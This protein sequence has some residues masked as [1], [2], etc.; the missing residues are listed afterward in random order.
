[1][2]QQTNDADEAQTEN[3]PEL[4][5]SDWEEAIDSLQVHM[6]RDEMRSACREWD[7]DGYSGTKGEMAQAMVEQAPG[8]VVGLLLEEGVD[9]QG[10]LAE[11]A[12]LDLEDED[13]QE[14]EDE[15]SSGRQ[16]ASVGDMLEKDPDE[17]HRDNA[18]AFSEKQ[19]EVLA[20]AMGHAG[21]TDEQVAESVDCSAR[22][23]NSVCHRWPAT[24][25]G[26]EAI[27]DAGHEVPERFRQVGA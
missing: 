8:N 19:V 18:L 1:M 17:Y 11:D 13:E 10:D 16:R 2:A 9:I 26:I 14:D 20:W 21:D 3:D 15:G 6:N 7:L 23:V 25:E 24:D 5:A 12:G 4:A 27:E 22:Y